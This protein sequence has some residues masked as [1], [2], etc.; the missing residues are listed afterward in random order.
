MAGLNITVE[1]ER[2][3]ATVLVKPYWAKYHDIEPGVCECVVLGLYGEA[4]DDGAGP[5]AVCE[6]Y[7]GYVIVVT[8]E[9]I[10]FKVGV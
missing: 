4:S 7:N 8:P 9:L 5:V 3:P 6:L 1:Q 10:K 2:R